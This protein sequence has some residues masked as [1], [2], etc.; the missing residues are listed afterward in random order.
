MAAHTLLVAP[1]SASSAGVLDALRDL[2]ALG[3]LSSFT[4]IEA[5]A[6]TGAGAIPAL[7]VV[8]GA[9]V[10]TTVQEALAAAPAD[11]VRL[12]VLAPDDAAAVDTVVEQNLLETALRAAGGVP[13]EGLRLLVV[14]SATQRPWGDVA[15]DGWHNVVVSP[16]ES[17]GPARGV[18]TLAPSTDP[19]EVG[20]HAAP[21][22]AA[23]LGLWTG[24]DAAPLD[25][26]AA[27][28][29]AHVRIARSYYRRLDAVDVEH[30]L[31]ARVVD[32]SRGL[33]R[34]LDEGTRDVY[35]ED[36]PRAT[37][38]MADALWRAHADVLGTPVALP[39]RPAPTRIGIGAAIGM[40]FSFLWSAIKGAPGAWYRAT[41]TRVSAG[42]AGLTQ[43]V[44]FGSAPSAFAVVVNGRTADGS[45]ASWSDVA[46]VAETL[47]DAL[48]TRG[49]WPAPQET[50]VG[51]G[52][53][54]RDVVAGALTL[55]D[56]G[57]R[58]PSLPPLRVD[59]GTGVLR[60]TGDAV[61]PPSAR[62][63]GVGGVLAARVPNADVAP[64]DLL[65]VENLRAR[66]YQVAAEPENALAA[67]GAIQELDRW[68][69]SH[70]GSYAVA[71]GRRLAGRIDETTR[72]LADFLARLQRADHSEESAATR[73]RQAALGKLVRGI[74]LGQVLSVVLVI[75]LGAFSILSWGLVAG[76]GAVVLVGG[77]VAMFVSFMRRQQTL[78]Q[79]INEVAILDQ[80]LAT[81]RA[82][83]RTVL[84]DHRRLTT[85]YRQYLAW[86][87][88]LGGFLDAPL[89]PPGARTGEPLTRVDGLPAGVRVATP[90]SNP[91]AL[92]D[93]AVGLRDVVFTAGWLSGPWDRLVAEAGYRLGPD[94]RDL[95]ADPSSLYGLT[96]TADDGAL[97][98]WARLV[99]TEGTG[100][101]SADAWWARAVGVLDAGGTPA[102][103]ALGATVRTD[104]GLET[105]DQFIAGIDSPS[106]VGHYLDHALLTP[107]ARARAAQEVEIHAPLIRRGGLSGTL[108]LVQVSRA[109]P[110][111]DL[112]I[113]GGRRVVPP[114][115]DAQTPTF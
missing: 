37:S 98:R 2:S 61:P 102:A 39:P 86:C 95:R 49:D 46:D 115:L 84:R 89:G 52:G 103:V 6:V 53:L 3:M 113:T 67:G 58:S 97:A 85:A 15:R 26:R 8:E 71:V 33:P 7:A 105:R 104:V 90:A 62:F 79:E 74:A 44:V 88:A 23:L 68:A 41:V 65:G 91:D 110:P 93:A 19:V 114:T 75:A 69:A 13:V 5:P 111:E 25:G 77:L 112:V 92:E 63:G 14:R 66:L 43:R 28:P 9:A 20:R 24:L 1:S 107:D 106:G 30:E 108:G 70:A 12:A 48:A 35:L 45:P 17:A 101:G 81:V 73:A 22:I 82:N 42:A 4:W 18:T 59:V 27:P 100:Q 36:V 31:R 94:G 38:A 29:A 80:E 78:F 11:R 99:A 51:L 21:T 56:G 34:P 54:W 76:L 87:E 60:R 40:F 50:A 57:R 55:C 96:A 83:L 32:T 64:T 109:L 16:E 72:V 47:D 10:A